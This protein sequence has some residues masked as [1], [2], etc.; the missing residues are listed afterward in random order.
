MREITSGLKKWHQSTK[1]G[2]SS[3]EIHA[4]K[5]NRLKCAETNTGKQTR[6]TRKLA[7]AKKEGKEKIMEKGKSTESGTTKKKRIRSI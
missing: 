6:R 4:N 5:N 2:I 1:P 7:K 3:Q